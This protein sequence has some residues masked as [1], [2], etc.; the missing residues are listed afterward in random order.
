MSSDKIEMGR[1][2]PESVHQ[3]T[4][5]AVCSTE[6][7]EE[8]GIDDPAVRLLNGLAV[9][10][11][12]AMVDLPGW[13]LD[14][15]EET[16]SVRFSMSG[17]EQRAFVVVPCRKM[18]GMDIIQSSFA[19]GFLLDVD[20]YQVAMRALERACTIYEI[21]V[22]EDLPDGLRLS[23]IASAVSMAIN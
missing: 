20:E 18:D 21:G 12:D 1:V 22:V 15:T 7:I 3:M 4:S 9:T 2:D 17:P 13:E 8:L 5:W 6:R 10:A 23:D 19:I 11:M 16:M 14:M